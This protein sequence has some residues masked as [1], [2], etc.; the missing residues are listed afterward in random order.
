MTAKKPM[1]KQ[2]DR[3]IQQYKDVITDKLGHYRKVKAKLYMKE[4]AI[5]EFHWPRPLPLALKAKV[6]K[7]LDHQVKLGII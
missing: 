6:E 3:L 7:E 5:R 4:N 1:G 2:L